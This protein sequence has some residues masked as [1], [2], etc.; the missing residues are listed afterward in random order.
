MN[1]V[2]SMKKIIALLLALV[3][4]S[5]NTAYSLER[6]LR[7]PVSTEYSNERLEKTMEAASELRGAAGEKLASNTGIMSNNVQGLL[8]NISGVLGF[9]EKGDVVVADANKLRSETIDYLVREAALNNNNDVKIAAQF[10]I[11]SAA[12]SL[13]I[14]P[15]SINN[16]Y[17]AR[18]DNAW[19]NMTVP[20]VNIRTDGYETARQ[21]FRVVKEQNIGAVILELAKSEARYS[22][23]SLGEFTTVG[24]A[25]AI[26]EGY[27]GQIFFQGDHY[28]VDK[29]KYDQ[30]SQKEI[31]SLKKFIRESILAGE[32]NIDLDPSTLVNETALDEIVIL[33]NSLV[34]KHLKTHPELTQG[35][36]E[37][38][39]KALRHKLIDE[40]ALTD[41]QKT[42]LDALYERM[43][44]DTAKVTMEL[45]RYIRSLE[46]ELLGGKITISIGIEERHIDNPK[47]KN[48]PSTVRGSIALA[49]KVLKICA[50]EGLIAP[51]KIALQTGTM[52]GLGGEVDFGI[53]ERH[54]AAASALGIAVFVQHGASTIKDRNDFKKMPI[55]GVGEVH[56]ATEYQKITLGIIAKMM[57]DL[58]G[59]MAQ[60]LEKLMAE[61]PDGYGKKFGGIWTKAFTDPAQ[62]GKTRHEIIT[63]ILADELPGKLQGSLKDLTKELS[64]PFKNE[65]WNTPVPVREAVRQAL[66][67]E[68]SE[69][70]QMI[71]VSETK[72]LVESILPA[73]KQPVMLAQRPE[74][75]T[76]AMI[77]AGIRGAADQALASNANLGSIEITAG[78]QNKPL[79]VLYG[80]TNPFKLMSDTLLRKHSGSELLLLLKYI[81]ADTPIDLA[82]WHNGEPVEFTFDEQRMT[83][84]TAEYSDAIELFDSFANRKENLN[85]ALVE[86]SEL[87]G[88]KIDY[89]DLKS[90]FKIAETPRAR[91]IINI[92][93][94]DKNLASNEGILSRKYEA[95]SMDQ[96]VIVDAASIIANRKGFEDWFT[97]QPGN[98]AVVIIALSDNE[99]ENIRQY[100]DIA[101]IKVFGRDIKGEENRSALIKMFGELGK[102]EFFGGFKLGTPARIDEYKSV[103]VALA[104]GI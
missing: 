102:E 43:H 54:L 83:L 22:G 77:S 84:P 21:I 97:V 87:W 18:K 37:S 25:A 57:P 27:T 81:A 49:N 64:G 62:Q 36:D 92:E 46:K 15:A 98:I 41:A 93:A 28:Q 94:L 63:E 44:S 17:M 74:A 51:S 52:H 53:Y 14:I 82:K 50:E 4:I 48:N 58:A 16:F 23:Q 61:D 95:D 19:K 86:L 24:F 10:L 47:H 55:G 88:A 45:I 100:E 42:Q 12:A 73:A 72:Q 66:H 68:F 90:F 3:F 29:K 69:I 101:F 39:L 96:I 89:Q 40:L 30:D 33:E 85:T 80:R 78:I 9:D 26:K 65:I 20:A 34:D 99:Y 75:L 103:T 8:E 56:L 59:K 2:K 5:T 31:A 35:L 60:Y 13:G 91:T 1:T 70:F 104:S 67:K 32:Y 11:R 7:V 71:G 6:T 76:Q 79:A 38:G